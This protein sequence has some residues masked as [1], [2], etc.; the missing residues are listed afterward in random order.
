MRM[1]WTAMKL[2]NVP[3]T[4]E[5][6]QNLT[7]FDLEFIEMSTALDNPKLRDK[8]LNTVHD[9]EFD[10]YAD[11]VHGEELTEEERKMMEEIM[12]KQGHE[13]VAE[14]DDYIPLQETEDYQDLDDWEEVD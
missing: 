7:E 12:S 10:D 5:F 9:E 11:E 8:I 4:H 6:I 14:E 2:F 3:I 13:P 1:I